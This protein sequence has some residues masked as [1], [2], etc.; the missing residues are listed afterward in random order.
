MKKVY[1]SAVFEGLAILSGIALYY[2][3]LCGVLALEVQ[4][5]EKRTLIELLKDIEE[6]LLDNYSEQLAHDIINCIKNNMGV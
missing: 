3:L 4:N 5:M 2:M 1:I 6:I